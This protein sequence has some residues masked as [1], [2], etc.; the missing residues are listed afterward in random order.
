MLGRVELFSCAFEGLGAVRSLRLCRV[1]RWMDRDHDTTQ[2]VFGDGPEPRW[3]T[4]LRHAFRFSAF[5]RPC[6]SNDHLGMRSPRLWTILNHLQ[7]QLGSAFTF[8]F[9]APVGEKEGGAGLA[10]NPRSKLA[11]NRSKNQKAFVEK[12]V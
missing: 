5:L 12:G 4:V 9:S 8:K 2:E 3:E 7:L 10:T 1:G 11:A 6:R